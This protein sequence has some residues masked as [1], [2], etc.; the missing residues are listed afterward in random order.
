[1]LPVD[2][3]DGGTLVR[4]TGKPHLCCAGSLRV[5]P[6]SAECL[7]QCFSTFFDVRPPTSS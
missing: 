7:E 4:S 3:G 1:M 5:P 6:L 2:I